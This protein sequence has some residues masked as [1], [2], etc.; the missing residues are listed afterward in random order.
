[1]PAPEDYQV[2]QVGQGR[3]GYRVGQVIGISSSNYGDV[4]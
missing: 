2:S 1:M 3:G 4:S